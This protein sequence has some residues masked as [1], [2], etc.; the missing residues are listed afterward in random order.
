MVGTVPIGGLHN[1]I[2]R[3]FNMLRVTDKRLVDVSDI[4]GEADSPCLAILGKI[5]DDTRR[6][7]QMACVTE[8]NGNTLAYLKRAVVRVGNE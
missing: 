4:A 5:Q 7:K 8:S 3:K 6:A 2:I 1:H